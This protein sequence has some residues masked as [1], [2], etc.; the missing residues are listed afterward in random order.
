MNSTQF[1]TR[2]RGIGIRAD[3]I[4]DLFRMFAKK[5]QLELES[6][7]LRCDLFTPPSDRSGQ[8]SLF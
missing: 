2:M 3:S 6:K 5:H 1:G 4:A 7:P 8:L